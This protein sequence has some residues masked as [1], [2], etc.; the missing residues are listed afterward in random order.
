MLSGPICLPRPTTIACTPTAEGPANG[1]SRSA[2]HRDPAARHEEQEHHPLDDGDHRRRRG[3]RIG[4]KGKR[5][6]LK[7]NGRNSNILWY[8]IKV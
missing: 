2:V 3:I 1:G 4:R 5:K 8:V 7:V 6:D